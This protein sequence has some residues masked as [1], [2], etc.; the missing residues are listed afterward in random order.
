MKL[1]RTLSIIVLLLIPISQVKASEVLKLDKELAAHVKEGNSQK[2]EALL[3]NNANPNIDLSIDY[4]EYPLLMVAIKKTDYATAKILLEYNAD[5]NNGYAFDGVFES[6]LTSAIDANSI[7][8]IQLLLNYNVDIYGMFGS[9]SPPAIMYAVT[10]QNVDNINIVKFLISNG[11]DV[12]TM[13]FWYGKAYTILNYAL[14]LKKYKLI[15]LLKKEGAKE[16]LTI[17]ELSN[18]SKNHNSKRQRFVA[19]EELERRKHEV[20]KK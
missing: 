17:E 7:E 20:S 14:D 8:M 12:N 16:K 5:P 4:P 10:A 2:V 15:E 13:T 9:E 11:A 3:K 19:I 6:P 18:V 1:L